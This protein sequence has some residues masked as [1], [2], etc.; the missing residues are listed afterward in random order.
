MV[1]I[2]LTHGQRV[3]L[4]TPGGGGYGDPRERAPARVAEDV[5]NGFVS[6]DAALRDYGVEV[7]A[8]GTAA[9]SD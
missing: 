6:R 5:K 4:E 7:G 9:R 8:D 2:K 3:R 1:G